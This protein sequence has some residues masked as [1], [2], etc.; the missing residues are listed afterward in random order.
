ALMYCSTPSLSV[1]MLAKVYFLGLVEN[2]N[3]KR[4]IIDKLMK[5]VDGFSAELNGI[6]NSI[7]RS[8]LTPEEWKM[9]KYSL[10]TLDYGIGSYKFAVS[11]LHRVRSQI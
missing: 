9:T 4:V 5:A 8:E 2:D 6:Q 3:D 7:N 10:S 11:W 1:M